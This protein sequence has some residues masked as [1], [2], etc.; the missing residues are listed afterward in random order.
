MGCI[1]IYKNKTPILT[2]AIISLTDTLII[3]TS[4]KFK[5]DEDLGLQVLGYK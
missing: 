3:A 2:P 1:Q 5:A 4:T